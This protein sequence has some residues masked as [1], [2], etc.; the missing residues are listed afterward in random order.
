MAKSKQKSSVSTILIR[1]LKSMSD[2]LSASASPRL[3]PKEATVKKK[4][5]FMRL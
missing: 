2:H 3:H 5:Y 4:V 1:I